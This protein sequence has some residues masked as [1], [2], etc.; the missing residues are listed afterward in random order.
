MSHGKYQDSQNKHKDS[1]T[2]GAETFVQEDSTGG[3]FILD[4]VSF[5]FVVLVPVW[6]G[7]MFTVSSW[8][9]NTSELMIKFTR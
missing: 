5:P 1:T 7:T 6:P 4:S 8:L 3:I 2:S 9:C